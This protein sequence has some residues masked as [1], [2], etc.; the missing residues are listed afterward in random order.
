MT[1]LPLLNLL[2]AA[3]S[4]QCFSLRAGLAGR[5]KLVDRPYSLA[6]RYP[7]SEDIAVPTMTRGNHHVIGPNAAHFGFK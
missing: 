6:S 2:V 4:S 1:A 7:T 5:A 3:S